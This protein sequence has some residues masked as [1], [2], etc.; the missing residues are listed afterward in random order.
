MQKTQQYF[1]IFPGVIEIMNLDDNK[2]I[3]IKR[4]LAGVLAV[5]I[6]GCA[7]IF[8]CYMADGFSGSK[9]PAATPDNGQLINPSVEVPDTSNSPVEVSVIVAFIAID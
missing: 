5:I 4:I 7:I 8:A 9:A 3:L 1:I 2:R 6:L